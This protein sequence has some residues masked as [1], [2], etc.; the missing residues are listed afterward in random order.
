MRHKLADHLYKYVL[1]RGWIGDWEDMDDCST[2]R[3]FIK[4]PTIREANKDLLYEDQNFIST[5]H[6][7]N[8]FIKH[9]DLPDYDTIFELNTPI[10]FS[11]VIEEYTRADGSIDYGIYATKQS[12]L[13]FK[14]ERLLQSVQETMDKQLEAIDQNYLSSAIRQVSELTEELMESGVQLATFN[15]TH[16]EFHL[17]LMAM[18][19]ALPEALRRTKEILGSRSHRRAQQRRRTAIE[20]AGSIPIRKKKHTKKEKQDLVRRIGGLG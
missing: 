11:G 18:G 3:V 1:C 14:L 19:C 13:H 15:R 2:R 8:L 5:E 12:T 16:K 9:E 10:N 20:E 6:H 7:L 17:T 4:Q